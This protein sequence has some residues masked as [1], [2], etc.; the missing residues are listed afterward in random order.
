MVGYKY[1]FLS[2]EI[3]PDLIHLMAEIQ[4]RSVSMNQHLWNRQLL[5]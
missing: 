1:K 4:G 3:P 2:F 5:W